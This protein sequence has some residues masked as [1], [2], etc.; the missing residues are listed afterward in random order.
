M[1]NFKNIN[2]IV[3][4]VASTIIEAERLFSMNYETIHVMLGCEY[5][6]T[7]KNITEFKEQQ[8]L[9]SIWAY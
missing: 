7:A 1:T 3:Y 8:S 6:G 2:G 9:C 4:P 5:C